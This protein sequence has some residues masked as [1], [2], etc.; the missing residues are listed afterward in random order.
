MAGLLA[1]WIALVT[2]EPAI[3]SPCPMHGLLAVAHG[4]PHAAKGAEHMQGHAA[5][6]QAPSGSQ[7]QHHECCTCIGCC[8]TSPTTAL[9]L[10]AAELPAVTTRLVTMTVAA[11]T[12]EAAPR[13][14]PHAR[15][16]PTGPPS[17]A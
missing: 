11:F 8:T 4:S 5:H 17:L 9:P 3:V 2:G 6:T 13:G 15:P 10:L 16:Y 7:H 14:P 1:I 12:D